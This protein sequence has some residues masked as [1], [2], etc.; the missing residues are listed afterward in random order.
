MR[1]AVGGVPQRRERRDAHRHAAG[2]MARADERQ[3]DGRGPSAGTVVRRST[4]DA[5]RGRQDYDEGR[6][7]SGRRLHLALG[8]DLRD[9]A[10]RDRAV[11]AGSQHRYVHARRQGVEDPAV[12]ML[13]AVDANQLPVRSAV[14]GPL[15][16]SPSRAEPFIDSPSTFAVTRISTVFPLSVNDHESWISWPLMLPLT[17]NSPNSDVVWPE[18]RGPSCVR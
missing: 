7:D 2:R 18:T 14:N 9:R 8:A 5:D 4:P 6:A 10:P 13:D 12:A 15:P 3:G 11:G 1:A 17:G 16:A